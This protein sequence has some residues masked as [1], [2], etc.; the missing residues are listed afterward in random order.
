MRTNFAE[1]KN[2]AEL[3]ILTKG[4]GFFTL[5]HIISVGLDFVIVIALARFLGAYSYGLYSLGI[6]VLSISSLI[7][8]FGLNNGVLKYVALYSGVNNEEK[9]KGTII[10]SIIFT[11]ALG[12]VIGFIVYIFSSQI[13]DIYQKKD[14]APVIKIFAVAIP[15]SALL[16]VL[17][18]ITRGFKTNKYMVIGTNIIKVIANLV[19]IILFFY[20]GLG[21]SGA[22]WANI[23]GIIAAV[24]FFLYSIKK[25]FPGIILREIVP[26]FETKKLLSTSVPL[27]AIGMISFLIHW[28][29]TLMVGYFLSAEDVGIYRVAIQVATTILIFINAFNSIFAST[30]SD[31]YY[32]NKKEDLNNLFKTVT[33]WGLY[34]GL[35]VFLIILI[36]PDEILQ[37]FG[38]SFLLGRNSLLLL[39]F[40][41]IINVGVGAT[42]FMLMMTNREKIESLNAA[43][44]LI[45]NI[46]LN[47]ILIPRLGIIGA[48]IATSV[49]IGV[50]NI[51]RV[52][53]IYFSLKIHPFNIKFIKGISAASITFMLAFLFKRYLLLNMHYLINL[54]LSSLFASVIFFI[55]LFLFRFE[56]EDKF[57]LKKLKYR[58]YHEKRKNKKT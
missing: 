15:F 32:R 57:I 5:G 48:A 6:I 33:R 20:L 14:L 29:D 39:S 36:S 9:T 24:L 45:L 53:E 35:L 22:V 23:I 11:L 50:I 2:Q 12:L 19:F 7:A 28:T 51:L 13:A 3:T 25:L 10:Q 58:I 43:G 52:I 56:E 47:L 44:I 31:F 26:K 40:G 42:G 4:A 38:K 18:G 30:I 21:L 17:S 8:R 49:S 16:P 34:L 55:L 37:L 46:I 27:L 41:Q 54:I 1:V